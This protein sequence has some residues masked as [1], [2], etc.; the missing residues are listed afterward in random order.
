MGI[1]DWDII[2]PNSKEPVKTK[3]F[4]RIV[5]ISTTTDLLLHF[6]KCPFYPNMLNKISG[7]KSFGHLKANRNIICILVNV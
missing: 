2:L 6:L 1:S 4:L 7:T 3:S 5:F